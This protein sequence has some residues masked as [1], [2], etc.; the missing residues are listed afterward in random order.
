MIPGGA[1]D[2]ALVIYYGSVERDGRRALAFAE[3]V[4]RA[5]PNAAQAHA[6]FASALGSLGRRNEAVA[7]HQRAVELEPGSS[8]YERNLCSALAVLR[9]VEESRQAEAKAVTKGIAGSSGVFAATRF[10]TTGELPASTEG[11]TRPIL[12][13]VALAWAP[14]GRGAGGDRRGIT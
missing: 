5:L 1:G 6:Q 13:L 10:I 9:R 4:V 11:M 3:N 2:G 12:G 7:E 14:L 8:N